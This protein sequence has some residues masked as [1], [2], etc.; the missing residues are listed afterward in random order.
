MFRVGVWTIAVVFK[1]SHMDNMSPNDLCTHRLVK[2]AEEEFWP[3]IK[4]SCVMEITSEQKYKSYVSS[5]AVLCA[6][7]ID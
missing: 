3:C 6:L 5:F 4:H 1:P 2:S 7:R